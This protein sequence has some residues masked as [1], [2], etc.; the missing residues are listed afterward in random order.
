MRMLFR[1]IAG[2]DPASGHVLIE[3]RLVMRDSTMV[4]APAPRPVGATKARR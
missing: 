1:Q 2:D 3:P 4:R